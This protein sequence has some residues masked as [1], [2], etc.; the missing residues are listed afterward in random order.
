MQCVNLIFGGVDEGE[1]G[2]RRNALFLWRAALEAGHGTGESEAED[3]GSFHETPCPA[4]VIPSIRRLS[5]N[6]SPPFRHI[7]WPGHCAKCAGNPA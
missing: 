3:D 1:N 5:F 7:S 2:R 4:V 6:S